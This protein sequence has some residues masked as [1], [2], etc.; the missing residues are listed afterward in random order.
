MHVKALERQNYISAC[1][2]MQLL[3]FAGNSRMRMHENII[4][5]EKNQAYIIGMDEIRSV[6]K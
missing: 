1:K 5:S 4:I 2:N 3:F 6:C